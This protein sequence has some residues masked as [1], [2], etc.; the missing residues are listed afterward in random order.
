MFIL[1]TLP[2]DLF[3]IIHLFLEYRPKSSIKMTTSSFWISFI[4]YEDILS[5]L[6]FFIKL[7]YTCFILFSIFNDKHFLCIT[8][9][10]SAYVSVVNLEPIQG[11]LNQSLKLHIF[12]R[13]AVRLLLN[14]KQLLHLH[15]MLLWT[16]MPKQT[17]PT[18]TM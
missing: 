12:M 3:N 16:Q 8:F 14:H 5:T 1:S 9:F 4:V 15:N 13:K 18:I 2:I 11:K 17:V 6:S 10:V 7:I